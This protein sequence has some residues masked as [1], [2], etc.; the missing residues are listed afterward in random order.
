MH[1]AMMRPEAAVHAVLWAEM[2]LAAVHA[3]AVRSEAALHAVLGT[4][5]A[6]LFTGLAA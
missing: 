2:G 4:I 3:P 5:A 6:A 1:V